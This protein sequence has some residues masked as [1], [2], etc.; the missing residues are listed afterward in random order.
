[1]ILIV[2]LHIYK[3]TNG[4]HTSN[5]AYFTLIHIYTYILMLIYTITNI[6]ISKQIITSNGAY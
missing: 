2:L 3:Y 6:H 5:V 4:V 1:M